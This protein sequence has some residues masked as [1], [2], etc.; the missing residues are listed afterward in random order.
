MKR[1][2]FLSLS[3]LAACHNAKQEDTVTIHSQVESLQLKK[4]R[5]SQDDILLLEVHYPVTLEKILFS[6]AL[7]VNDI[8][9][10]N[11]I[12]LKI[13]AL[14]HIIKYTG[15]NFMLTT[16]DVVKLQLGGVPIPVINLMIRS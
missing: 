6:S 15:S 7:D 11:E 5:L 13:D 16:E 1:F 10:L 8:L 3:L 14:I 2:L 12:G 4:A 9:I